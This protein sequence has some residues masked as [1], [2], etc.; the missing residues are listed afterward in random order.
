MTLR[1]KQSLFVRYVALLIQYAHN[2]GYELTFGD[3]ARSKEE[4][5][6]L[7]FPNSN[8]VRRLAI[9]LNLFK[10]GKYLKTNDDHKELGLFWESLSGNSIICI[11]GGRFGDG[12]HYSFQHGSVK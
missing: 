5:T 6:R 8:H 9:D 12:N 11:W 2:R 1:Q 4:A 10:N 3:A 7:G